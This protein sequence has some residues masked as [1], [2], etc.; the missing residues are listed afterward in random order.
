VAFVPH[1]PYEHYR[2]PVFIIH[3]SEKALTLRSALGDVV[4]TRFEEWDR[5]GKVI[6][7]CLD[8]DALCLY[9]DPTAWV[10]RTWNGRVSSLSYMDVKIY[11]LTAN[12][13][14]DTIPLFFDH[15]DGMGIAASGLNTMSLNA[16]RT[17]L[18]G[19]VSFREDAPLN[20]TLGPVAIHTGG[21]KEAKRGTYRHRVDYDIVA[22]YPTALVEPLPSMLVPAPDEFVRRM[23][24]E[25]WEGIAVARVR[26]PPM[27][28]GPLPVLIDKQ[29]EI[30]CYGFTRADEWAI[31]TLPLSELRMARDRGCDVELVKCHIG[32]DTVT[33]FDNWYSDVVPSLRGL[34]GVAGTIGK[35]VV[36]R[37]WSCFAVSPNGLR[38]E[39]T[40]SADGIMT[41]ID[42]PP[43]PISQVRR[44]AAT[45]YVGALIQSRVRQ[46]LY[47]EGLEYFKGVIYMDTDGVVSK[48]HRV[49][50]PGWKIK[51]EMRW[52]DIAG[53]QALNYYCK[54][55]L[56]PPFGHEG[57]HWSVAGA[58]SIEA[59]SRLFRMMKEGG[60][61]LSNIGNTIP[62]QEVNSAKTRKSEHPIITQSEAFS[63]F[64]EPRTRT[65]TT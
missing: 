54:D 16:W 11:P 48:P 2:L 29:S 46:R 43:D 32:T 35:L 27:E 7:S 33:H 14:D 50:P 31:V 26:I 38:K 21:R 9:G 53:P 12:G 51:H 3:V 49:T 17:T 57:P 64:T 37:L 60:M 25:K 10:I 58:T 34:N 62:A 61:L 18:E 23:D 42:V 39:H 56:P 45:T 40:F 28:W 63:F 65:A 24:I 19:S 8:P 59:K 47:T 52:L 44:R 13:W 36:N 5:S 4:I 1:K 15:V 30:S 55:C 22:A 6:Y 20:E 41:T